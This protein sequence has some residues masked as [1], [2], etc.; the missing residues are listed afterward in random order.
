MIE[1]TK[2]SL[3]SNNLKALPE[4]IGDC[5]SLQEL[6]LNNNAKFTTIPGSAGHLRFI[7]NLN[8]Y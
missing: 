1:L 7:I 5:I 2:L 8:Y 6:Y 4:E 3:S